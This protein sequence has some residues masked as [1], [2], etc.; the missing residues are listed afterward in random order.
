MGVVLVLGGLVARAVVQEAGPPDIAAPSRPRGLEGTAIGPT[1]V[2]LSWRPS[3]DNVGVAGYTLYRDGEEVGSVE[4]T[5]TTYTD[6]DVQPRSTYEYAV[7]AFDEAGNRSRPSRAVSVTTPSEEDRRAPTPPENL[8]AE[9]LGPTEVSLSWSASEDDVAVQG[10]TVYRDGDEVATV[11][12]TTYAD[13]GLE[14]ETEYVYEVQAFDAAGNRSDR[15]DPVTVPTP[16]APDEK[17]P[18]APAGLTARITRTPAPGPSPGSGPC[19]VDLSWGSSTDNT[20]VAGYRIYRNGNETA[21]VDGATTTYTDPNLD[22]GDYTYTVEAFDEAGNRSPQSNTETVDC[23]I[24][25]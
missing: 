17:A 2:R 16:P 12:G 5:D 14:P 23:V 3:I 20:R 22:D 21:T 13:T 19:T 18:T 4:G 7:D 8:E 25:E 9:A 10:Y 1:E 24:V 6:T 11:E 15:S